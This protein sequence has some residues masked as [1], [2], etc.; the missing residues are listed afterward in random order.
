MAMIDLRP[1]RQVVRVS[2][3]EERRVSLSIAAN[4]EEEEVTSANQEE[5]NIIP[6]NQRQGKGILSNQDAGYGMDE[7]DSPSD[8]QAWVL[9]WY[10]YMTVRLWRLGELHMSKIISFTLI[11]VVLSKVRILNYGKIIPRSVGL[12]KLPF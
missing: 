4:H 6:A 9:K 11:C 5:E 7:N 1:P 3:D 12:L 8:P 10:N 2:R